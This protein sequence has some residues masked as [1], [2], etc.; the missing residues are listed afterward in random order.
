[1]LAGAPVVLN[2]VLHVS[3]PAAV[4]VAE[5]PGALE[6]GA[7]AALVLDLDRAWG[8]E[9]ALLEQPDNHGRGPYPAPLTR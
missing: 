8:S 1:M 5:P 2:D 7:P 3:N 9:G 4:V 6:A